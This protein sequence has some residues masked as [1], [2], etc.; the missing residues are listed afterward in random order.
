VDGDQPTVAYRMPTPAPVVDGFRP[1]PLP[2]L[3]G[4]RG[5]DFATV[6][7]DPVAAAAD[8]EVLFAGA[9][10]GDLHVTVGHAD[11]LRTSYSFLGSVAVAVGEQ[12]SAGATIGTAAGMFHFGV[13]DPLGVYLD[14]LALFSRPVARLV[15]GGDD[16]AA[17]VAPGAPAAGWPGGGGVATVPVAGWALGGWDLVT[18]GLMVAGAPE[19]GR[20]HV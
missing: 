15:P 12:V 5:V 10:G 13:R 9:V 20:A 4:N 11:G 16:G 19:I 18:R 17:P 3:A 2:W 1:P 14:P 6:P 7:G 8:G